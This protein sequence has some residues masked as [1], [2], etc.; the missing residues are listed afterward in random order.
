M[1]AQDEPLKITVLSPSEIEARLDIQRMMLAGHTKASIEHFLAND[2]KTIVRDL[3]DAIRAFDDPEEGF[4]A[5]VS[6]MN[7][8]DEVRLRKQ[9]RKQHISF[10]TLMRLIRGQIYNSQMEKSVDPDSFL[11]RSNVHLTRLPTAIQNSAGSK[12]SGAA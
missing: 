5:F 6:F 8:P 1:S 2:N 10:F 11:Q 12:I 4:F 3:L 7:C 9:I